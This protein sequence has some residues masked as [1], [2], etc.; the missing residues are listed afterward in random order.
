MQDGQMF[1]WLLNAGLAGVVVVLFI[2]GWIVAKPGAERL[3]KEAERWR[4]L[5]KEEAAAHE[6]TR[7]A[8]A[9]EIRPLLRAAVEAARTTEHL[10]DGLDAA[11]AGSRERA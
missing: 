5:Y 8:H 10:L 6:A 7:R 9:E 1:S 11:A 3:E 4:N 2:R